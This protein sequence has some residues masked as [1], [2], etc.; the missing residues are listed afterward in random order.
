VALELNS[1]LHDTSLL[2]SDAIH[3]D[4]GWVN[5]LYKA[6][7]SSPLFYILSIYDLLDTDQENQFEENILVLANSGKYRYHRADSDVQMIYDA[8]QKSISN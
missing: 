2:Y 1:V 5:A 8:Y 3:W 4:E 7:G 6:S